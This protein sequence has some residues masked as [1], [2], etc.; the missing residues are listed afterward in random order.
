MH[1]RLQLGKHVGIRFR[2]V[3]VAAHRELDD[4]QSDRPYVRRDGV[5]AEVVL[6]FALDP[7]GLKVTPQLE[8]KD[9]TT[10]Q[11]TAM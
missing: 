5:C 11:L 4:A 9:G 3:R 10:A 6:R 1:D 2:W 8:N 7:F